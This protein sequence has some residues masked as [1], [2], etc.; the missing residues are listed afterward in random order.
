MTYSETKA[1]LDEIAAKNTARAND[2][3]VVKAG[4]T[5]VKSALDAMPARYTQ[6]V[7]DINAE[8]GANPTDAAWQASK[9][10]V[11]LLV[12]DFLALQTTAGEMVTVL[13]SFEV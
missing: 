1:L 5:N 11:A 3:R 9:A 13:E 8:A 12:D 10:E 6:A 2:L 7:T 4:A